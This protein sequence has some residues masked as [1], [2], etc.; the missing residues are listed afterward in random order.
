M[1]DAYTPERWQRI[2]QVLAAALTLN[3]EDRG[4]F[5]AEACANDDALLRE[6]EALLS[7]D[8]H[9]DKFLETPTRLPT[10]LQSGMRLGPYEIL[11]PI[12]AGGM[13]EVYRG[14]DTR[15]QRTVA[16]KVLSPDVVHDSERRRRF[17]QEARAASALSHP[18]I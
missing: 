4:A 12:G 1:K 5:V 3:P 7:A 17:L 14:R 15:L 11:S 10:S 2:K 18:N 6:G 9:A 8:G 13:G 16:I